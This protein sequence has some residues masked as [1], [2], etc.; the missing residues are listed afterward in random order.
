MKYKAS[1]I[2]HRQDVEINNDPVITF[3]EV[4]VPTADG[5]IAFVPGSYSWNR[6]TTDTD[7]TAFVG[8]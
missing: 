3:E 4:A 5:N 7:L 2:N 6:L 1:N 8:Q